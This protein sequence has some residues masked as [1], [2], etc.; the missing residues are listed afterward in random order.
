MKKIVRQQNYLKAL[1]NSQDNKYITKEGLRC[2]IR[3]V[4]ETLLDN[5]ENGVVFYRIFDISDLSGMLK[6]LEFSTIKSYNFSDENLI[7]KVWANTE[8]LCLLTHRFV[9]IFLWDNKTNDSNLVRYYS[10]INSRLQNEA[11]DII[12]R[13]SKFDI[14]PYL[15]RFRPDRRDNELLNCSFRKILE[16]LDGATKDAV[17]GFVENQEPQANNVLKPEVR[18]VVHEIRNQLSICDLYSEIVKKYCQNNNIQD[19]TILNAMVKI[20]VALN[21]VSNNLI[22][23]KATDSN[24]SEN[25]NIKNLIDEVTDLVKVYFIDKDIEFIVE[26][27]V[28]KEV[29][30]DKSKFFAVIINIIKNALEAFN[31]SREKNGKYI[32]IFV[33]KNETSLDIKIQNNA[34]KIEKTDEIFK[35][36]FTTK[37]SGSGYGLFIAKKQIEEQA[38]KLFLSHSD[39]DYT[40]FVISFD[41]V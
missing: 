24:N 1:I 32:K 5:P 16:N 30:V 8:F 17:L 39:D 19:N 4:I 28:E 37:Q 14:K 40:E 21:N 34:C 7:E 12:A 31:L 38:G 41:L 6:R 27:E 25:Y 2:I 10:I 9:A 20:S 13:N 15:E 23:L 22:E 29:L 33:E 18:H 26:N 35:D 11:L 3:A 36:G